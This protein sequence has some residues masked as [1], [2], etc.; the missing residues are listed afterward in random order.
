MLILEEN[1]DRAILIIHGV[2]VMLDNDLALIYGVATKRLNEQVKRNLSRFPKDF[3]FQLSSEEKAEVVA[4]CDHLSHLKYSK[5]NPYA[6]TEHGTIMLAAVLNTGTAIEVSVLIVRSFVKL[7]NL[8]S[9]EENL[10]K[11]IEDLEEKYDEQFQVV[12]KVIKSLLEVK[13]KPRRE[14]GFRSGNRE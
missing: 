12:F 13:S 11:K 10:R 7:R 6:F 5:T 1:I 2:K 3:M 4:I 9:S 14:I 8:V